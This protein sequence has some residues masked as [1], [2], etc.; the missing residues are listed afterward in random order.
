MKQTRGLLIA[1]LAAFTFAGPHR[2]IEA[3]QPTLADA[4]LD[5]LVGD[6]VLTGTIRHTPTT[7]DVKGAWVLNHQFVQLHEV[8]REKN[9]GTNTPL[10][11]AIVL[12]GLDAKTNKYLIHWM[13]VY[14]GGF[15]LVGR[16]DRRSAEIPM[17][18]DNA[19]GHFFTTLTYDAGLDRWT[20]AMDNEE[21]GQRTEFGRLSM[22]R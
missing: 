3:Q 20:W 9:T 1:V 5:H 16:A 8:S 17:V 10:Y 13:D 22:A 7:H 21:K 12:I 14:G 11:E 15:S 19:D 6:W 18:F 2:G 4:L